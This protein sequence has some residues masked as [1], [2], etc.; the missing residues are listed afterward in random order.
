MRHGICILLLASWA[1]VAAAF[2]NEPNGFGGIDWGTAFAPGQ[3]QPVHDGE[4]AEFYV[5]RG[6]PLAL[7]G[8]KLESLSYA[9]QQGRFVG[10]VFRTQGRERERELLAALRD[11][12]GQGKRS[13]TDGG[14]VVRWSGDTGRVE[15]YCQ[16][17]ITCIGTVASAKAYA[18]YAARDARVPVQQ[19]PPNKAP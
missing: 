9:Y 16:S 13:G 12:Y 17:H 5:R 3:M 4:G 10:V 6:E 15:V 18:A 7:L 14:F 1:T 19:R 8:V 2:D 11:E